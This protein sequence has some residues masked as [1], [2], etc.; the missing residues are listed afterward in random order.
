MELFFQELVSLGAGVAL[1][2][3]PPAVALH[4]ILQEPAQLSLCVCLYA[5]S[6]F[7]LVGRLQGAQAAGERKYLESALPLPELSPV[8][9]YCSL[10]LASS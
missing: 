1:C 5:V 10:L 6:G 9:F 3:F 4:F 8:I 7:E 2:G